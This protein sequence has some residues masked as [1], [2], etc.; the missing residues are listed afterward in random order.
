VTLSYL[1]VVTTPL[2]A[3]D[4]RAPQGSSGRAVMDGRSISAEAAADLS[5]HDLDFPVIR[6]FGETGAMIADMDRAFAESDR[7]AVIAATGYVIAYE[8]HLYGGAAR[9]MSVDYDD[10]GDIGWNDRISSFKSFGASGAF[11]QHSPPGGFHFYFATSSQ[12]SNVGSTYN[13]KFSAL[14]LD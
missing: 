7:A 2:A 11:R 6:C 14:Q 1:T 4:D 13:D 8:H 5:C 9:T 10:L 12:I 3:A